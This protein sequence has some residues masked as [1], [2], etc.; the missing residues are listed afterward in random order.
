MIVDDGQDD[1]FLDIVASLR[2]YDVSDRHTR[3]LRRR[4]HAVMQ[5]EPRP[6]R[7]VWM[8]DATSIRRVI[9][10][11]LGGAWCVLYLVEIVRYAAAIY[12]YLGTQ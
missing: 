1:R 6:T 3:Q 9:V 5:A 2:T 4:C 12:G 11:A 8:V 7:S 10:P